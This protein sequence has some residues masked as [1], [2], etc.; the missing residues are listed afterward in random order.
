MNRHGT[1]AWTGAALPAAGLNDVR[2][3]VDERALVVDVRTD[4]AGASLPGAIVV[5]FGS[6]FAS[7]AGAVVPADTRLFVLA[8]SQ[9]EAAEAARVLAIVGRRDVVGWISAATFNAYRRADGRIEVPVLVDEPLESQLPIDV[10]STAEWQGRHI[11]GA[12][13]APLARL[14]ERV[15]GLD[16]ATPLVVYCQAGARS[17]V[18][19]SAL[20]QMGFT[21]VTSLRGGLDRRRAREA[22]TAVPA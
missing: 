8:G 16:R 19:A 1:A 14:P 17:T 20:R 3:L 12:L 4:D 6:Q 7:W 9:A 21:K 11:D 22:A 18:A 2:A 5:P 15:A 13:H 10:R